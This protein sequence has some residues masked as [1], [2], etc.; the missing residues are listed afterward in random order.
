[1]AAGFSI[2]SVDS[3][4]NETVAQCND[5][6][7]G[8]FYHSTLVG[9]SV[10]ERGTSYP[11]DWCSCYYNG[12]VPPAIPPPS[13]KI[14]YQFSQ[15]GVGPVSSTTPRGGWECFVYNQ[16][17]LDMLVIQSI[18][19]RLTS[20]PPILYIAGNY[21]SGLSG[22]N[23]RSSH[24]ISNRFGHPCPHT[25][26]HHKVHLTWRRKGTTMPYYSAV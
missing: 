18:L 10:D 21:I 19:L 2:I 11:T 20:N 17:R 13:D 22:G 4:R 5:V 15:H 12:G 3:Y 8:D 23:Q 14:Y 9:F 26:R 24:S 25:Y 1:V 6:C 7:S 16:V